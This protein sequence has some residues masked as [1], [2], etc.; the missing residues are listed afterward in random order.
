MGVTAIASVA[1]LMRMH[2]RFFGVKVSKNFKLRALPMPAASVGLE[3]SVSARR[4]ITG[5]GGAGTGAVTPAPS[6]SSCRRSSAA[7]AATADGGGSEAGGS[8]VSVAAFTPPRGDGRMPLLDNPV[9]VIESHPDVTGAR[10]EMVDVGGI[11]LGSSEFE[12][13]G[14]LSKQ[15]AQADG[16]T[17]GGRLR[18]MRRVVNNTIGGEWRER[19]FVLQNGE[20]RYWRSENDYQ[21]G[22]PSSEPIGL[23]AYEVLVDMASP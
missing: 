10:E 22:K 15:D 7:A 13:A 18:W 9:A 6:R 1:Y 23:G 3:Q 4:S 17:N 21:A 12:M 2:E 5:G 14:Y 11:Q 16:P 19:F 8:Q 20:L